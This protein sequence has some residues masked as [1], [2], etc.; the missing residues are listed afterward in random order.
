[1]ASDGKQDPET[2][3]KAKETFDLPLR[4]VIL[5]I[6]GVF[7]LI[8]GLLLFRIHT[9][10]LRYNP[11]SMYGLIL[12]IVSLQMITIGKTPFGDLR[13]SW[14]VVIIGIC[15]AVIGMSACF[16]PGLLTGLIRALVG[17]LLFAGGIARL[18]QL[19]TAEDKA[20]KWMRIP[21]IL[22]Q[23]TVASAFMYLMTVAI[24]LVLLLP[25]ITTELQTA[26]LLII[27]GISFIYL[28]WCIGKVTRLYPPE[29]TKIP[30][31]SKATTVV[32]DQKGFSSLFGEASLPLQV[33]ILVLFGVLLTLLGL[34]L[35]PV[36]LGMLPFSIDGQLGLLLFIMA[37]QMLTTGYTPI[38]EYKRSWL[39][40]TIGVVFASMGM[41]SCIVPGLLTGVI[42][43]LL[44]VLNIAGG[45]IPLIRRYIPMLHDIRHSPAEPVTVTPIKKKLLITMTAF[46][47]VT[48]IFGITVFVHG[49]LEGMALAGFLII[50]GL[51]LFALA[52]LLW[53]VT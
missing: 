47:I 15:M 25:G 36:N 39:L 6:L 28:A 37:V 49:L 14:M 19:F 21:G 16:I 24:G 20:K 48:L 7:M 44:G 51:L 45:A 2:S 46:Y 1:M 42:W 34:L 13:R 26:V 38:G 29:E 8:F 3:A 18:I 10:D 41:V 17:I 5:F 12:V 43:I 27:F 33:A 30:Y 50:Y 32:S 31:E 22:R 9:G 35:F 23:L 11:D 52:Y 53:Q 40:M 4:V